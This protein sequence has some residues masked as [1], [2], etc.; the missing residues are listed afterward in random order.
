MET[1]YELKTWVCEP[2]ILPEVFPTDESLDLYEIESCNETSR[3]K[4]VITI[5]TD[6]S[7]I[8]IEL[9]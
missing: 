3:D 1:K 5:Y 4:I 7:I 8:E 2:A 9:D 6:K